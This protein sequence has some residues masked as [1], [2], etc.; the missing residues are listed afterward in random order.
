MLKRTAI[1]AVSLVCAITIG[2]LL[3]KHQ[4]T[5]Q[6]TDQLGELVKRLED[7]APPN[8]SEAFYQLLW[9]GSGGDIHGRT[10]QI[11]SALANL[12]KQSP[13]R[14]DDIK[15]ALITLL[16]KENAFVQAHR[17]EYEQTGNTLSEAYV[18]YYGDLIRCCGSTGRFQ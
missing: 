6:L 4:A 18:D 14:A 5:A 10:Y 9:I 2:V 8:R 16:E 3:M 1:S 12:Y 13:E 11:P 7:P 15:I 17:K